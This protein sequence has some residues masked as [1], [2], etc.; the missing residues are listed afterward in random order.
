MAMSISQKVDLFSRKIEKQQ[1]LEK[2]NCRDIVK[3]GTN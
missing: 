3:N 1:V 2:I